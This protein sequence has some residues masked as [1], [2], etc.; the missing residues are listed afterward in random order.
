[1][2]YKGHRYWAHGPG[3][4]G[5]NFIWK[6]YSDHPWPFFHGFVLLPVSQQIT[7]KER[8][9]LAFKHFVEWLP[10]DATEL[11]TK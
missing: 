2:F 11:L 5:Q 8:S 10:F 9:R 7:F 6:F 3:R 1:M 4:L